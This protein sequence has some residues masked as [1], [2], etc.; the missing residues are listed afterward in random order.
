MDEEDLDVDV[1]AVFV[2]EVLQEVGDRL[3]G[4][5]PADHDVLLTV[6]RLVFTG[7]FGSSV[8]REKGGV[9]T[10]DW[11]VLTTWR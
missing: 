11:S 9:V 2:Q 6:V 10:R 1:F 5:V 8:V 4:N 3:E 7:V